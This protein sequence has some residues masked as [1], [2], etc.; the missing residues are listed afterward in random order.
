MN[1]IEK[2]KNKRIYKK[3]L[4]KQVCAMA[5]KELGLSIKWDNM[6][7]RKN[8][9]KIIRV[10]SESEFEKEY[11][12]FMDTLKNDGR[13]R[14]GSLWSIEEA[15]FHCEGDS[16]IYLIKYVEFGL[17]NGFSEEEYFITINEYDECSN[18][19]KKYKKDYEEI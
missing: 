13:G 10:K 3:E 4:Y 6:L 12:T 11:S 14:L 18:L 1:F 17:K 16:M 19:Y 9:I 5:S 15:E 7:T 8:K 2:I